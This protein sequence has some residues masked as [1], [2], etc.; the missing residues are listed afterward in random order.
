MIDKEVFAKILSTYLEQSGEKISSFAERVKIPVS[1][2]RTYTAASATPSF[3][4]L[5]SIAQGMT[6]SLEQLLRLGDPATNPVA[7]IKA[8]I[9]GE[10]LDADAKK[11]LIRFLLDSL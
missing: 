4:S 10:S 3:Q 2:I 5:H 8:L 9:E 1:T 11:D 6:L 7:D